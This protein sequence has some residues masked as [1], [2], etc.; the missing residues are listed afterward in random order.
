[1]SLYITACEKFSHCPSTPRSPT[2]VAHSKSRGTHGNTRCC[3]QHPGRHSWPVSRNIHVVRGR[4]WA[5]PRTKCNTFGE[6]GHFLAH[7]FFRCQSSHGL[8][9]ST[10]EQPRNVAG[11]VRLACDR[12]A[13]IGKGWRNKPLVLVA[14]TRSRCVR[15]RIPDAQIQT[16][17]LFGMTGHCARFRHYD[18]FKKCRGSGVEME[19]KFPPRSMSTRYLIRAICQPCVS[20]ECYCP[21]PQRGRGVGE[22]GNHAS[23][24]ALPLQ[25]LSHKVARGADTSR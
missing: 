21:S 4:D 16:F 9:R 2:M 24:Q 23:Q 12:S 5:V 11:W 22:G 15:I 14:D 1:M 25:P 6:P 13:P 20:S 3:A 10:V 7:H 17:R 18:Q 8:T 19:A